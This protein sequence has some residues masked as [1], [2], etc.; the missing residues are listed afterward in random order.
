MVT[1]KG[2][3][4]E[5]KGRSNIWKATLWEAVVANYQW[6]NLEKLSYFFPLKT[7]SVLINGHET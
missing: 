6:Q 5:L 2:P 4:E 7:F 1:T 3:F